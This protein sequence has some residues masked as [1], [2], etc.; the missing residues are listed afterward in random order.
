VSIAYATTAGLVVMNCREWKGKVLEQ[1]IR[2]GKHI[3]GGRE[4][5]GGN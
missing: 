5:Q 2:K 1:K 3:G 4:Q